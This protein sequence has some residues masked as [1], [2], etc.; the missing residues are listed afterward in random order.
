MNKDN[1]LLVSKIKYLEK[2]L[3]LHHI[4]FF[5]NFK[6]NEKEFDY[7]LSKSNYF[8]KILYKKNLKIF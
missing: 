7:F 6:K 3:E 8:K 5:D 4:H 2:A 1:N